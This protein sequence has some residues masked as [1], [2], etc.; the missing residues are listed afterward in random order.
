MVTMLQHGDFQVYKS[1]CLATSTS[2]TGTICFDTD[3]P[4]LTRSLSSADL[5]LESSATWSNIGAW[6]LEAGEIRQ[7]INI[8]KLHYGC[9]S[10]K[11]VL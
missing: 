7:T 6:D 2:R 1:Y 5:L 3:F 9:G 10:D 4:Y 8:N 11:K